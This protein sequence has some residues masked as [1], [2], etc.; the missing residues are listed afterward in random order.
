MFSQN[1][2]NHI[3][4]SQVMTE[5]SEH[6]LPGPALQDPKHVSL[7]WAWTGGSTGRATKLMSQKKKRFGEFIC[8]V[9]RGDSCCFGLVFKPLS[10]LIDVAHTGLPFWVRRTQK[11]HKEMHE[12]PHVPPHAPGPPLSLSIL[13]ISHHIILAILWG[14]FP[15]QNKCGPWL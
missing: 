12:L 11:P 7:G 15:E 8:G 4:L 14:E 1:L 6:I 9:G 13:F 5:L 3:D 10:Q 2:L